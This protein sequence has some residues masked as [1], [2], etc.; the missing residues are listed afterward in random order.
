[1][2]HKSCSDPPPAPNKFLRLDNIQSAH[3]LRHHSIPYNKI[4]WIFLDHWN[5]K[6][7]STY[8]GRQQLPSAR[9]F[10]WAM[11][12]EKNSWREGR[13][14][15]AIP[16]SRTTMYRLTY[17]LP[18]I[19]AIIVRL[20]RDQEASNHCIFLLSIILDRWM[21]RSQAVDERRK[22]RNAQQ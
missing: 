1:M 11:E 4:S 20:P 3:Y 17:V 8:S 2:A 7:P 5:S 9:F 14:C 16:S 10:S 12:L 21:E 6:P 13:T 19:W 18:N 22:Q 15:T